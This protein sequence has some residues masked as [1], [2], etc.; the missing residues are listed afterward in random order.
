MKK[1]TTY[2][3]G[4]G[5]VIVGFFL[6]VLNAVDYLVGWSVLPGGLSG[7]GIVLVAIGL[8]IAGKNKK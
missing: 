8:F 7:I 6:I 3:L 5:S 2:I 1:E 4:L